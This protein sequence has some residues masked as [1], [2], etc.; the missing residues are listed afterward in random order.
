VVEL[1]KEKNRDFNLIENKEKRKIKDLFKFN[2]I[3]CEEFC[4]LLPTENI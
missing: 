2:I 1:S 3:F 4:S